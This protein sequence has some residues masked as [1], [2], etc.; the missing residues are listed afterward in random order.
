MHLYLCEII[1]SP[2]PGPAPRNDTTHYARDASAV[3]DRMITRVLIL[4]AGK[5]ML[6]PQIYW[7]KN[8]KGSIPMDYI[9]RFENL[10]EDFKE[11]CNQMNTPNINLPHQIKGSDEDYRE[12]FDKTSIKIVAELYNEEIKM[13]DYSFES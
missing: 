2:P 10:N 13:F 12:Y 4:Y 6:R 1:L 5:G 8:F 3:P 7:I 9:G 11:I